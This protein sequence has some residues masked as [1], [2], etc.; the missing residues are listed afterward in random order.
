[1]NCLGNCVVV[2]FVSFLLFY[3]ESSWIIRIFDPDYC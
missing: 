3:L 2:S 1:M